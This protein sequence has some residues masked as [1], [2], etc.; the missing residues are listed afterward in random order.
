MTVEEYFKSYIPDWQPSTN[1]DGTSREPLEDLIRSHKSLLTEM[2]V[3][4]S[5][6]FCRTKMKFKRWVMNWDTR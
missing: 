1:G 3:G 6:V 5:C 2:S 4:R